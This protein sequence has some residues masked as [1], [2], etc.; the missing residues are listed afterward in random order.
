M[1]EVVKLSHKA[2]TWYSHDVVFPREAVIFNPTN[3]I[4]RFTKAKGMANCPLASARGLASTY[5]YV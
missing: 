3:V 5:G 2:R 4:H 1:V